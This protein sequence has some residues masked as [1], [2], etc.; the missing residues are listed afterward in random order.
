M[1]SL[2]DFVGLFMA[3]LELIKDKYL[4][5]TQ[6]RAFGDLEIEKIISDDK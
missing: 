2:A 6:V 1:P 3:M 5:V 4:K